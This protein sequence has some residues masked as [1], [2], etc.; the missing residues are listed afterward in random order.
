LDLSHV[1]NLTTLYCSDN[2]LSELDLSPVPLLTELNCF[3]NPMTELDIRP[4][5]SLKNLTYDYVR[6][7]RRLI[8][9]PDQHFF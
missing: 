5:L 8:Q 9:R 6:R 7:R 3:D 1:P 4:L 2:Q